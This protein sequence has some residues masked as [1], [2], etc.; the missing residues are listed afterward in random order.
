MRKG[1]NSIKVKKQTD[2]FTKEMNV[3]LLKHGTEFENGTLKKEYV[4]KLTPE[5]YKE[6]YTKLVKKRF[7][8]NLVFSH[9]SYH[10]C[11]HCLTS[12]DEDSGYI[13]DVQLR[14]IGGLDKT[15]GETAIG[16]SDA[17][18]IEFDEIQQF[19]DEK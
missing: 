8:K 15:F 10:L 17:E 19:V 1:M 5:K 9:G 6:Y 4:K 11:G 16:L 3:M 12:L 14:Y 18:K 7:K 13:S 2:N